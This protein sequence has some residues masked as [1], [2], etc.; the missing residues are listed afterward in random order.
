MSATEWRGPSHDPRARPLRADPGT[1]GRAGAG[2]VAVRR[3]GARRHKVDGAGQHGGADAGVPHHPGV[4][5]ADAGLCH[6]GLLGGQRRRQLAFGQAAAL[7]DQRR[8]GEPRG[9]DAAVGADPRP[10]RRGGRGVRQQPPR[11]PARPRA[12]RA[13]ADRHGLP[14]LPAVHLEPVRAPLARAARRQRPQP[15]AAGSGPRL[16]SAAALPRLCRLLGDLRLRHRRPARGTG[17]R[18]LGALG[19]AVDARRAGAS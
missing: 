15:A 16:P 13:G 8:V 6:V 4:R 17:R 14:R 12:R 3:R 10:V 9:L 5:R 18:R 19:A 1:R 2:H 7:Q 11:Q